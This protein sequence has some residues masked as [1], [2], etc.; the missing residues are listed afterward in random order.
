MVVRN[1]HDAQQ[2]SGASPVGRGVPITGLR[3]LILAL[4]NCPVVQACRTLPEI[5]RLFLGT[6]LLQD[7]H[8]HVDGRY[9]PV[10]RFDRDKLETLLGRPLDPATM[11]L[12][13]L[14]RQPGRDRG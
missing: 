7:D 9:H 10:L 11:G 12:M 6:G 14:P 2:P 5:E 3:E 4:V 1:G 13:P 8:L